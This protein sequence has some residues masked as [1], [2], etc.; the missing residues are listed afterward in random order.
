MGGTPKPMQQRMRSEGAAAYVSQTPNVR[1]RAAERRS[2]NEQQN[3]FSLDEEISKLHNAKM[4]A[5]NELKAQQLKVQLEKKETIGKE[6]KKLIDLACRDWDKMKEIDALNAEES[7]LLP[8]LS[9]F[10]SNNVIFRYIFPDKNVFSRNIVPSLVLTS[11][12]KSHLGS[13]RFQQ[14]D[15][16]FDQDY[17]IMKKSEKSLLAII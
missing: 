3:G 11:S 5:Q 6:Y 2:N 17:V 12:T 4:A 10:A 14:V 1:D 7:V 9:T 15:S 16:E 13:K 8:P